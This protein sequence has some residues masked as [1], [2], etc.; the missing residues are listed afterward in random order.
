MKIFLLYGHDTECTWSEKD[1]SELDRL[2]I[3]GI[4]NGDIKISTSISRDAVI[5]QLSDEQMSRYREHV[6][7]NLERA[8]LLV[9]AKKEKQQLK[10]ENRIEFKKVAKLIED[11]EGYYPK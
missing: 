1:T 5:D 6:R 3:E 10:H 2:H 9:K 11:N 7:K 4:I 8:E